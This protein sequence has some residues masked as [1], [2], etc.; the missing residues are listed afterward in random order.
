M[1]LWRI[2]PAVFVFSLFLS[3]SPP[4]CRGQNPRLL[5]DLNKI[6]A[7]K[8]SSSPEAF[9]YDPSNLHLGDR[10]LVLGNKCF[11]RADDGVHGKELWVSGGTAASTV[12]VKDIVPGKEGSAP[13]DFCLFGGRV[14]FSAW[15]PSAGREPWVTDGT[16]QGTRMAADLLPG[17][18]DG[19]FFYPLVFGN[20]LY[21]F[22][23]TVSA[24]GSYGLYR[25]SGTGK[26]PVLVKGGFSLPW[27]EPVPAAGFIVFQGTTTSSGREA[28]VTD[29]TAKGTFPLRDYGSLKSGECL[30]PVAIGS[31]AWFCALDSKGWAIWE[32]GGKKAFRAA[33]L[34][35]AASGWVT[36]LVL[37]K[38]V[39]FGFSAG[40]S[41]GPN[42]YV[43][44][45]RTRKVTLLKGVT[46]NYRS[47]FESPIRWKG[48]IWFGGHDG[49]KI[50]YLDALWRT[51][52]T[53]AGTVKVVPEFS[54]PFMK[55]LRPAATSQYIYFSGENG[56][57]GS[58]FLWRT[59]GTKA[60]TACLQ[61]GGGSAAPTDPAFLTSLGNKLLFSGLR[62]WAERELYVSDGTPAG[63]YL[64]KDI[65]PRVMTRGSRPSCFAGLLGRTW[66]WANTGL[67][68]YN[69]SELWLTDGTPGGTRPASNLD[70]SKT[71]PLF[72]W[73]GGVLFAG[74]SGK[75]AGLWRS[76]GTSAGT[77]CFFKGTVGTG[78]FERPVVLG[79]KVLF[80]STTSSLGLEPWITDGT[81]AGT[82][83]LADTY[84]GKYSG[85]FLERATLGR[86]ALFTAS[87]PNGTTS[88]WVT[89]GTSLGTKPLLPGLVHCRNLVRLGDKVLF[90]GM[91]R[92]SMTG[93]EVWTTDGSPAGTRLLVDLY[94]GTGDGGF[95][96]PFRSGPYVYFLG[97][98]GSAPVG[99]SFLFRTDGTAR[100]TA[101]V[102]KDL[103]EGLLPIRRPWDRPL[104][105][106]PLEGGR[107]VFWP[108]R[109]S[110]AKG[111]W[112]TDG[113]AAGT[114]LLA[115]TPYPWKKRE[116]VYAESAPPSRV[117]FRV[118]SWQGS[119][120]GGVWATDGTVGGTGPLK[121]VEKAGLDVAEEFFFFSGGLLFF[122][123]D[124]GI[125]GMEPW[126]LFPGATAGGEGW[127]GGGAELISGAPRLGRSFSFRILGFAPP[128]GA[129]F[130]LGFPGRRPLD[131]GFGQFLFLDPAKP[132]PWIGFS[133]QGRGSL[134]V[135]P[136]PSLEG[137]RLLLQG[138][139]FPASS[140]PLGL[141]FT[142]G[143]L[144]TLGK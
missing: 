113:T 130:F 131:L 94:P 85:G 17:K 55:W 46:S 109:N 138:A 127:S 60:G 143:I 43:F 25:V 88:L 11:F 48:F 83:L 93:K 50:P 98:D 57:K 27:K 54:F 42:P 73:S 51:D 68:Y 82:R 139:A 35:S 61:C 123:A 18:G 12:V 34:P 9:S 136:A 128:E 47:G 3:L 84:P 20:S 117:F 65:A 30:H 119:G 91:I 7:R 29:G 63:T 95:L 36:P 23:R 137:T 2:F 44:D 142:Q 116:L 28:W 37:G 132:L 108:L 89:D 76:D 104:Y 53:P 144:L 125:H 19:G 134:A 79:G 49:S 133:P 141:D 92:G 40:K 15:T 26:A 41:L 59:D 45:P 97:N 71:S 21:F 122:G 75:G 72:P 58:G 107:A 106:L 100:G 13:W 4:P 8:A 135:P 78:F 101:K 96:F 6:V 16:A 99:K 111:P 86:H 31:R 124:D 66:F 38:K 118:P 121:S 126:A 81:P 114:R 62:S 39:V 90:E 70:F 33:S 110:Q 52:G 24:G 22:G 87:G 140:P 67:G 74:V 102:G 5:G 112:V 115:A 1:R 32:T 64:L 103:F 77:T 120:K 56:P 129:L 105:G 69:A 14:Y 80:G 10:F